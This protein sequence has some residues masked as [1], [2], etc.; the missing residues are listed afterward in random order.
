M[1]KLDE[2]MELNKSVDTIINSAMEDNKRTEKEIT[3]TKIELWNKMWDD[4]DA[5]YDKGYIDAAINNI[6]NS[7]ID[8]GY[9]Y[10][11]YGIYNYKTADIKLYKHP[12]MMFN[13]W[14]Y[15]DVIGGHT[16]IER[17]DYSLINHEYHGKCITVLLLSW[18]KTKD[19]IEQ[20]LVN[21]I[22]ENIKRKTKETEAIINNNNAT[23]EALKSI[24]GEEDK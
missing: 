23:L 18:E 1:N 20:E 7:S 6:N 14:V 13:P 19:K 22:A 24:L 3:A 4:I 10:R 12:S 5:W 2:L 21:S 11:D 16:R 15:L 8:I 9:G 17:A